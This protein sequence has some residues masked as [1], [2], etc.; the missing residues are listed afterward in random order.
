M[1]EYFCLWHR[2]VEFK[3][4][5]SVARYLRPRFEGGWPHAFKLGCQASV[6]GCGFGSVFHSKLRHYGRVLLART[7]QFKASPTTTL[8]GGSGSKCK[9][10]RR[11]TD[12]LATTIEFDDDDD[13]DNN[14][15]LLVHSL[16]LELRN[17]RGLPAAEMFLGQWQRALSNRQSST[18][19]SKASVQSCE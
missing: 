13:D 1:A 8:S 3:A 7:D 6:Q 2:I 5:L 9:Q 11:E 12:N 4:L 15:I 16:C 17:S 10:T 18:S 19:I 14:S